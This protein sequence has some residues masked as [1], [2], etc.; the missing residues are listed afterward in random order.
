MPTKTDRILSYLPR[1]F[2]TAPRPPVLYAV[3]DAFGNELLLGENSLAALM[4]AH[5]VD[6]A[7]KHAAQIDD[8]EKMAALYGLAPRRG[9]DG[10]SLESVEEFREHLKHYVR[11]FLEGTVTVQGILRVSAEALGLRIADETQDLERWWT[12]QRD[13]VVTVEPRGDDAAAQLRFERT[14]ATGALARPAE[15]TGNIDLSGGIELTGASILRL[16]VDGVDLGEIDL[17]KDVAPPAR[18]TLDQIVQT[19][20]QPPRPHVARHNGRHLTLASPR[21]G[22][23]SRL[24]L[25]GGANDA[26]PPLLG[27]VPR[28]Y[29]GAAATAAQ[30]IGAV[31]LS[32]G[33]NLSSGRFLRIEI[34][35]TKLSEIDCAGTNAASTSLAQIREAI[36]HAF[37]FTIAG[38]DGKHLILTSPKKGFQSAI[39]VQSPA[40]QNAAVIIFGVATAFQSGRDDQPA[41]VT[42][43]RDLRGGVD[44][45]ERANLRLRI[46]GGAAV[47]INCAGVDP[48]KTQRIEIVA[49]INDALKAEVANVTERSVSLTSPTAG[50]GSEIVFETASTGDAA[51]DIFGVGSLSFEGSAAT[52][53]RLTATPALTKGGVDVRAQSVLGLAVDGG[54]PIEFD[55]RQAAETIAELESVPLDKLASRI[56]RALG[57]ADVATTDGQHL[58]F[59]SPTT[60]G[61]SSLEVKPLEATRRRR[62]VTRAIVTD[63]ATSVIFAFNAKDAHGTSASKARIVGGRDLSQSVDLSKARLLRLTIDGYRACEIDCAGPRARA[64]TLDEIV[65]RINAGLKDAGVTKD[66]AAHDGK[67]LVLIS[68]SSGTDSKLAFEPPRA[69]A[70]TLLGVELGTFHGQDDSQVRFTGTVD[71]S[72]GIDLD[73]NAAIKLGVDGKESVE[74]SLDGPAPNHKSIFDISTKI[75][76]SLGAVYAGSDG[77]HIV[78]TSAKTG[79]T[80]K[81]VFDVPSGHDATK[82]IFGITPPRNYQGEAAT[83]ARVE[84]KRDLSSPVDVSALGMLRLSVDGGAARD[85]DCFAG[86]DHRAI[87]ER[88]LESLK[89]EGVPDAVLEK[90]KGIKDQNVAGEAKFQELVRTTI[91]DEQ[92]AKFESLIIRHAGRRAALDEIIQAIGPEIASS[93]DGRHLFLNSRIKG[94]AGQIVL[95]PYAAGDARQQL[96]GNVEDLTT[97]MRATP[98]VITGGV[99]LLAPVNLSKRSLLR[100]AVDDGRARNIDV[101]GAVPAKTF[102]DEIVARINSIIPN[103]ASATDDDHLKLTSP[104]A[105]EES[106]LSV[107]P[108]RYLEVSEYVPETAPPLT[109]S[110]RHG[111]HQ[112]V[113]NDGAAD[114]YAEI[115]LSAPQGAVGPTIVNSTLGWSVRLFKALEVDESVRLRR[116]TQGELQVEITSHDGTKS[117]VPGSQIMVGPLGAQAWV[118][119]KEP[120]SLGDDVDHSATLQLNNPLAPAIVLLRAQ[121][122]GNRIEVSV[123]ESD[124]AHVGPPPVA[125]GNIASL[126]GRLSADN[127]KFS[128]VDASGS[129]I[130]DLRAGPHVNLR[131]HKDSVVKVTGPLHTDTPPLMIVQTITGLFDVTLQSAPSSGTP[132]EEPYPRVTIGVGA[133]KEDS[134]VRQINTGSQQVPASTLVRA[135]ELEKATVLSLPR[136]KTIFRYLDC[137]GSRFNQAKFDYAH[138]PDGICGE[139]GI[140]DV[141]RFTHVPPEQVN[142]VFASADPLSDPPVKIDFRWVVH[143]PGTFVVNLPADLPARFGARFNEARFSQ[144]KDGPELYEDA[145]A[146]PPTDP[147]FLMNLITD[148]S[149]HFLKAAEVVSTKD[150]GWSPVKMPFRKPQFLT[151]GRSGQAARLYLA[152]D[153]LAGFIKL[154]A[155]EEGAWGNEIAVAARQVGPAIYDVTVIYRGGRFENARSVVLGQPAA[156][157]TQALLRPGPIGVLQA[158]AA[159]VRAG[160]TRDRAEYEQLTTTT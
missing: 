96:L 54:G 22:P 114:T 137:L 91:G 120:W 123:V 135:E 17:A 105:G 87:T 160:V 56:N 112:A 118:P 37:G 150:L 32:L 74:I 85:I 147:K 33:A 90:L 111:D 35:G 11:T 50:P 92:A 55:L 57:G 47:T 83:A 113:P 3:A 46:D 7:D 15:V 77:K 73:P 49:A 130:A 93:S 109:L 16:R 2:Q 1:T 45:S 132:V 119:F 6:F 131:V 10:E 61:A 51:A 151:L 48:S 31:D 127:G 107:L 115:M 24:Q 9:E 21:S 78:L 129:P 41:R 28:S 64:T 139:R 141:S 110:A 95:D 82:K 84:G 72:A 26:A 121:Q 97:G 154:E 148:G 136:G 23:A 52:K 158:K 44:L 144:P 68:P 103:L 79:T 108:L 102:L 143:Q 80:S 36:N 75:N 94:A 138:F 156:E 14:L 146:E 12:R 53:A 58:L 134:L 70:D 27:L 38:D 155:K 42:S 59:A 153:G 69:A 126:L 128:L 117:L 43:P 104:N 18:L 149:S 5:W 13:E 8:L 60:G 20:N 4:L 19:I 62:F 81:L 65:A 71:L 100:L 125:D 40:A 34:D 25:L 67:R 88:S 106:H 89:S 29:H 101:A 63:E 140:F 30:I 122:S 116:D 152:E 133:M 124:L 99:D 76:I 159:G 98:A 66:V 86:A 145:V 39:S 157:L 142:A